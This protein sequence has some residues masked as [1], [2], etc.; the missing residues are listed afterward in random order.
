MDTVEASYSSD[1]SKRRSAALGNLT[2][3]RTKPGSGSRANFQV[4]RC[5]HPQKEVSKYKNIAVEGTYNAKDYAK[6]DIGKSSSKAD[7]GTT[8]S[9]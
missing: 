2:S 1:V 5:I 8:D 6:N 7:E 9:E 3:Y 4:Y